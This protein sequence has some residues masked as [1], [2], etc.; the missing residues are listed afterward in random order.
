MLQWGQS[1]SQ[2]GPENALHGQVEEGLRELNCID[3]NL[4]KL[5]VQEQSQDVLF[6]STNAVRGD[7][8]KGHF[9]KGKCLVG[10]CC[11]KEICCTSR[12]TNP[13]LA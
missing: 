9:G 13:P 8:G 7:R 5:F 11:A 10:N 3:V 1:G 12:S 2:L 4:S 6:T